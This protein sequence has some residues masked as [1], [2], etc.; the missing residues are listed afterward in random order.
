MVFSDVRAAD[1]LLSGWDRPSVSCIPIEY[2]MADHAC[3]LR[4]IQ[5]PAFATVC[6]EW[7]IRWYESRT[8]L[9]VRIHCIV[10]MV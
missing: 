8:F 10:P 4:V 1:W 5:H 9:S 3:V 6:G 7:F 2:D